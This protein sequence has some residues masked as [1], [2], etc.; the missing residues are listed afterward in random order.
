MFNYLPIGCNSDISLCCSPEQREYV[1]KNVEIYQKKN[2]YAII[3]FANTGHK[4]IG[5]VA[6]GSDFAHINANGD[7]EPCAFCHYSDSNVNDMTLVEALRSPFFKNFREHKPF[8]D[9][10]LRP[11]PLMDVPDGIV[12]VTK[13][14]GVRSTHLN[15]PE[16]GIQLA[17]KTRQLSEKWKPVADRLYNEMPRSE[18]RRFAFIKSLY[19]VSRLI[20]KD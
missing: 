20:K 11:C 12:S 14:P 19:R 10:S 7:M 4:A 18:K 16:S 17:E 6:A 13:T 8:S 9:N 5:C 3:D 1:K 2:N 15:N